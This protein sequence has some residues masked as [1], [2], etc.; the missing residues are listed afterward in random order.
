MAIKTGI[1]QNDLSCDPDAF[2]ADA[3]KYG[4][5]HGMKI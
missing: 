3:D 2:V 5:T 4:N 1:L